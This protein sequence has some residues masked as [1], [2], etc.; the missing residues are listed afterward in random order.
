MNGRLKPVPPT[1]D[2]ALIWDHV[3]WSPAQYPFSKLYSTAL[4]ADRRDA[5]LMLFQ[6]GLRVRLKPRGN[7]IRWMDLH[8][9]PNYDW[10]PIP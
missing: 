5:D 3:V 6:M 4:A 9:G 10:P 7:Y 2:D 1:I 8:P